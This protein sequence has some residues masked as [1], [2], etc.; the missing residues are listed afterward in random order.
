MSSWPSL[1]SVVLVV[2]NFASDW[3]CILFPARLFC[4][5]SI[6]KGSQETLGKNRVVVAMAFSLCHF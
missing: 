2:Y 6:N 1:I 3:P 4:S 5:S